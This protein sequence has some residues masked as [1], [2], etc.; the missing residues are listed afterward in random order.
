MLYV[1]FTNMGYA[2]PRTF[3]TLTDAVAYGVRCCFEFTVQTAGGSILATWSPI[4]GLRL[5]G[6]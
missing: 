1:H 4:S 3:E 5:E 2:A 6:Y